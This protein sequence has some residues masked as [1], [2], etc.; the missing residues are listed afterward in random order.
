M[1]IALATGSSRTVVWVVV[2]GV[3]ATSLALGRLCRNRFYVP[4]VSALLLSV[5]WFALAAIWRGWEAAA[6]MVEEQPLFFLN[7]I[8]G[9][10]AGYLASKAK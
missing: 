2:V 10:L 9:L 5:L 3:F 6:Y 7:G 1:A 4:G 8:V